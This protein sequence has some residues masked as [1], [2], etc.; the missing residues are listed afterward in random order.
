MRYRKLGAN[1]RFLG[2]LAA[3]ANVGRIDS[4]TL[5]EAMV[6]EPSHSAL[7]NSRAAFRHD[8]DAR[9]ESFDEPRQYLEHARVKLRN[10]AN[11]AKAASASHEVFSAAASACIARRPTTRCG[12]KRQTPTAA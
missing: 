11:S 9:C 3:E 1:G 6:P 10:S 12:S 2:A 5:E 7:A 8:P 4:H